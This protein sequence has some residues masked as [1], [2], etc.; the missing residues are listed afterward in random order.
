MVKERGV[1]TEYTASGIRRI[2]GKQDSKSLS[3]ILSSLKVDR[4]KTVTHP[5]EKGQRVVAN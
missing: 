5:Q 1:K 2:H 4:V 3:Q